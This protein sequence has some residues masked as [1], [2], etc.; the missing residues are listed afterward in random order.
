MKDEIIDLINLLDEVYKVLV[1]NM[2]WNY[3]QNRKCN[4]SEKDWEVAEIH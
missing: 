3:P 4:G 2:K 1:L